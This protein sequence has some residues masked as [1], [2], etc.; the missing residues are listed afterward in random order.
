MI[1]MTVTIAM[2]T[3]VHILMLIIFMCTCPAFEF[4]PCSVCIVSLLICMPAWVFCSSHT[5]FL[6]YLVSFLSFPGCLVFSIACIELVNNTL[7]LDLPRAQC[8]G[9]VVPRTLHLATRTGSVPGP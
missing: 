3:L 6:S 2:L 4:P 5:H 7:E 9:T 8:L 1:V